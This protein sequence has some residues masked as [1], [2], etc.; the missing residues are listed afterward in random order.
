MKEASPFEV[1]GLV[2]GYPRGSAWHCTFYTP[3]GRHRKK[4]S[5]KNK[6]QAERRAREIADLIQR[7]DW[8]A[9]SLEAQAH[10][11]H[12][13]LGESVSHFLLKIGGQDWSRIQPVSAR[14]SRYQSSED[15]SASP[16]L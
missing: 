6:R 12:L 7:E 14:S 9:L 5:T 3:A 2:K 15:S 11:Q 13:R 4:L 10:C 8:E 16:I 1:E